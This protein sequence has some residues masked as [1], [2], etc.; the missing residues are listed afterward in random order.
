MIWLIISIIVV[1]LIIFVVIG[2]YNNLVALKLK[3]DNAWAT[4][5]TQL[6]RRFDL[7]PNLLESVKG[8]MKYE[9]N[10]L[11]EIIEARNSYSNAKSMEEKA[12]AESTLANNLKSLFALAEAY[13]DLKANESFLNLQDQ[14]AETENKIAY[15]RQFYNDVVQMYN[16]AIM[17]FPQNIIAGMFKF[18]AKSFF[19]A[20]AEEK[21]NVKVQF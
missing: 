13:P 16:T 12:A 8:Y 14:L 18:T 21:E 4:I 19:E 7:I 3:V 17:S 2:M 15:S 11:K 5:D 6:K 1:L 9:E 10:T 20:S